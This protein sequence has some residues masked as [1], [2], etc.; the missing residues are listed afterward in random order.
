M[1]R[2]NTRLSPKHKLLANLLFAVAAGAACSYAAAQ[3][4]SASEAQQRY[5]EDVERCRSG[6]TSQDE[7]TC[8][9]EAGAALEEARRHR[10]VRGTPSF[11]QNQ[12][13]RCERL[14]GTERDDC[15]ALMSDP[16][17][18]IQGSVAGGGIIRQTTITIPGE[19]VSPGAYAPANTG[20][21][22]PAAPAP[23]GGGLAP[24][25]A[26][27]TGTTGTMGTGTGSTYGTGTTGPG[28]T[29]GTGGGTGTGLQ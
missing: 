4:L 24:G 18:Q 23:T 29:Y 8:M 10:L 25:A 17:P 1:M 13:A 22:A 6:Q 12:H 14:S 3:D 11:D 19:T 20:G 2:Y 16:N 27:S 28:S 9:R 7:K 5:K 21:L 15:M 26:P